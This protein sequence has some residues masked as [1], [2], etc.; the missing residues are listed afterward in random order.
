[1]VMKEPWR[2]TDLKE[3]M[4]HRANEKV[5]AAGAM[6]R[7]T[8][9]ASLYL[10]GR[11]L[12]YPACQACQA[13]QSCLSLMHASMQLANSLEWKQA[14]RTTPT[15][16]SPVVQEEAIQEAR[17]LKL[18]RRQHWRQ[19]SRMMTP[20]G[21]REAVLLD[22]APW[23]VQHRVCFCVTCPYQNCAS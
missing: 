19:P 11:C 2:L 1:M 12:A 17:E 4:R 22:S 21:T 13:C 18:M 10:L 16:E 7:P 15:R 20:V 14:T 9:T 8:M 3:P 5:G 6:V 23:I